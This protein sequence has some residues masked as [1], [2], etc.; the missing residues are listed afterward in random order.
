MGFDMS[1]LQRYLHLIYHSKMGHAAVWM[2]NEACVLPT[3]GWVCFDTEDGVDV[4]AVVAPVIAVSLSTL[5]YIEGEYED[6]DEQSVS[7]HGLMPSRS[8]SNV[9]RRISVIGGQDTTLSQAVW[10]SMV[11]CCTIVF[12]FLGH[13]K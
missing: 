1:I 3:M 6:G 10:Y 11:W 12:Y 4:V 7:V 9:L 2:M 5:S 8:F 13:I